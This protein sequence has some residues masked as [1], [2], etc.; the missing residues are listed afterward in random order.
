MNI[1][2][3][4]APYSLYY[5]DKAA[6]QKLS[7]TDLETRYKEIEKLPDSEKDIFLLLLLIDIIHFEG[8]LFPIIKTIRK[9][10]SVMYTLI[11]LMILLI[12]ILNS[13]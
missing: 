13:Y 12:R 8:Y 11:F 6:L 2:P 4:N 3:K 5:Y 10:N 7:K 1:A 9:K